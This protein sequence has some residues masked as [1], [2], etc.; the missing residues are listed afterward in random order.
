M[1]ITCKQICVSLS[2]ISILFVPLQVFSGCA[3]PNAET[4]EAFLGKVE[5]I[6]FG[7]VKKINLKRV[8]KRADVTFDLLDIYSPKDLAISTLEAQVSNLSLISVEYT[9]NGRLSKGQFLK[10]GY[11]RVF[12]FK[13]LDLTIGDRLLKKP[14]WKYLGPGACP[15]VRSETLK[16]LQ[17]T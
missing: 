2:I 7:E 15:K 6:A 9:S 4:E 3:P 12:F 17:E 16:K 11:Q 1:R 14:E 13:R 10:A 5:L 8:A